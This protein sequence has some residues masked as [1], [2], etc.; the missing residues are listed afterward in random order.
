MR[1][2]A[3]P[4][5]PEPEWPP[6]FDGISDSHT[7]EPK[8]GDVYGG[9]VLKWLIGVGAAGQVWRATHRLSG[10][11][12]AV[13]ILKLTASPALRSAFLEEARVIALMAHPHIVSLYSS[14][15]DYLVTAFIDGGNLARRLQTPLSPAAVIRIATQICSALEYAH[16][17]GVVHRDVKPEN[18][19]LDRRGSAFLTDFGLAALLAGGPAH[20]GGTRSYMPPDLVLARPDPSDDQY[21]LGRTLAELLMARRLEP[22]ETV[23]TTTVSEHYPLA[24]RQAVQRAAA[25]RREDR[26]PTIADLAAA[27][28][29]IDTAHLH[30]PRALSASWRP[31]QPFQWV[32]N[33]VC[34]RA[35]GVEVE[36]A[37]HLI[38][39]QERAATI[40]PELW[41]ELRQAT[42]LADNGFSLYGRTD[43]LGAPTDPDFLGRVQQLVVFMPGL[44]TRRSCWDQFARHL[45]CHLGQTAALSLDLHCAGDCKFAQESPE[46]QHMDP[47]APFR[48]VAAL[49]K[50]LGLSGIPA[51]IVGHSISGSQ[52]MGLRDDQFGKA[53][54][55]LA[56]T[57]TFTYG[58]DAFASNPMTSPTLLGQMAPAE[59]N[60]LKLQM[61]SMLVQGLE[62]E[63]ARDMMLGVQEGFPLPYMQ[64]LA[65]TMEPFRPLAG[66]HLRRMKVLV[67]YDDPL[68]PRP[69]VEMVMRDTGFDRSNLHW[70]LDKHHWPQLSKVDHPGWTRRNFDQLLNLIDG[71]LLDSSLNTSELLGDPTRTLHEQLNREIAGASV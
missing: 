19:V 14:G 36:V 18:I 42:G 48:M 50:L 9:Y 52:M 45:C 13:K 17:K 60:A 6:Q 66:S 57:P 67:A 39:A 35:L 51:C 30:A 12:A 31:V 61:W 69:T 49:L 58:N 8:P 53:V 47:Q 1:D 21:A 34:T 41:R 16:Q 25:A 10:G 64:K 27:L 29:Q 2:S 46:L 7:D 62:P 11:E 20:A 63:A 70:A 26:F 40:A 56:L 22:T 43:T 33:A 3:Q 32:R 38:S 24:L 68:V 37:D 4:T 28:H 55:R 59:Y 65:T 23:T 71:L 54:T 5:G 15:E 44:G